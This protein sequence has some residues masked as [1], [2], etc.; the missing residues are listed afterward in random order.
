[1]V[2]LLSRFRL[3]GEKFL[4]LL[5]AILVVGCSDSSRTHVEIPAGSSAEIGL[6]FEIGQSRAIV[7][8]N[9]RAEV[10][11]NSVRI[12]VDRRSNSSW[13]GQFNLPES[14][15]ANLQASWM[16]L[17]T[18]TDVSN[19]VISREVVIARS[20]ILRLTASSSRTI[21]LGP[22]DYQSEEFDYDNDG[23]SNLQERQLNTPVFDPTNPSNVNNDCRAVHFSNS[24]LF[25]TIG[26]KFTDVG[27]GDTYDF[28]VSSLPEL[29]TEIQPVVLNSGE[30]LNAYVD[31][32]AIQARGLLQLQH[33]SGSPADSRIELYRAANG[34]TII[35]RFEDT[36]GLRANLQ[37]ELDPGFY[38]IVLL[39]GNDSVDRNVL[40][41]NL[42]LQLTSL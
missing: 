25:P 42:S 28:G 16:E 1:M 37:V 15:V 20:D 6:P 3:S 14:G 26:F 12:D 27:Q 24:I 36:P 23:S 13:A 22:N 21:S 8:D 9:L 33:I 17:V 40:P 2:S 29:A 5:A 35:Q 39:P 19:N 11:V 41:G 34:E 7:L 10:T 18:V 31:T 32:I 30:Q 38:C 4:V